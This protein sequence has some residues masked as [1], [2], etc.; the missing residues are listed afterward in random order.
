MLMSPLQG[1]PFGSLYN[2]QN[3]GGG[4]GDARRQIIFKHDLHKE[5]IA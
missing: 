2:K 3:G 5:Y 4:G 1:I